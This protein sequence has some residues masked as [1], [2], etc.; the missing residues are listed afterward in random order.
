MAVYRHRGTRDE[1]RREDCGL[2]VCNRCIKSP[3]L[4]DS[5]F[6]VPQAHNEDAVGL[7]EATDGPRR[8]GRVSLVEYNSMGIFLLGQ[9]P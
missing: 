7:A 1:I 8:Q 9:P 2:C 5:G 4:T 3:D 6:L